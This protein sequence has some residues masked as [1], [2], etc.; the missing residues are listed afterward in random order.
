MVTTKAKA[1]NW[2]ILK[3]LENTKEN[4]RHLELPKG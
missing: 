2:N 1:M 3:T 4:M